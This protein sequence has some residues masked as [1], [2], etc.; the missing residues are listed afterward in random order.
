MQLFASD[1]S[2]YA[3]QALGI[4]LADTLAHAKEMADAVVVQYKQLG[5]PILTIQDAIKA[6]SF[7]DDDVSPGVIS[8]GD[9]KS[10]MFI[11]P[12]YTTPSTRVVAICTLYYSY[13]I[14]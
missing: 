5:K 14:L 9:A 11:G 2:E 3:G 4:V 8:I 7:F 13:I 10:E 6:S 1:V 12:L